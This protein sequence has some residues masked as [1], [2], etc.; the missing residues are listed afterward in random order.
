MKAA[1]KEATTIPRSPEGNLVNIAG[2]AKSCPN[3][4]SE[5]FGK[6][7]CIEAI[8]GKTTSEAKATIIHGHGLNA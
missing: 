6:A 8:S 3:L 4:S 5:I 7:S 2:Y 1:P